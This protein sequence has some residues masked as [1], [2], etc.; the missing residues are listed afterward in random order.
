LIGVAG[1]AVVAS[2]VD[3]AGNEQTRGFTRRAFLLVVLFEMGLDVE[4]V[5]EVVDAVAQLL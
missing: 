2:I 1:A 3:L 4:L 5:L